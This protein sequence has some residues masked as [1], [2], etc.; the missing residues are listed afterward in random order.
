MPPPPAQPRSMQAA[1]LVV[2]TA[3]GRHPGWPNAIDQFGRINATAHMARRV[4]FEHGVSL[5]A[6]RGVWDKIPEA[7]R[8]DGL[9]HDV[10]WLPAPAEGV[11]P[12]AVARLWM[13]RDASGRIGPMMV[14]SSVESASIGWLAEQ[15]AQRLAAVE[16][17]CRDTNSAELVRLSIGEAQHQIEDTLAML[18]GQARP[19]E[20]EEDLLAALAHAHWDGQAPREEQ[21]AFVT[22]ALEGGAPHVRVPRV[23]GGT[24]GLRAWGAFARQVVQDQRPV[25]VMARDRATFI[26]IFVGG[27]DPQ[28]LT[29]LRASETHTPLTTRATQPPTADAIKAADARLK[30]MGRS[31][32]PPRE[33]AS[34]SGRRGVAILVAGGVLVGAVAMWLV[35]SRDRKPDPRATLPE[36][37]PLVLKGGESG[38]AVPAPDSPA[39]DG[40][41]A[42]Q[43]ADT[44]I[45]PEVIRAR[46]DSMDQRVRALAAEQ[47][48]QGRP[49][50][51]L[52]TQRVGSIRSRLD[53]GESPESLAP[54]SASLLREVDALLS[55]AAGRVLTYLKEEA[56]RPPLELPPAA[57]EAWAP[58]ILRVPP[59]EGFE[60]AQREVARARTEIVADVQR[61]MKDSVLDIPAGAP[62]DANALRAA[63]ASHQDRAVR[64]AA[65]GR[66]PEAPRWAE[67]AQGAVE[68]AVA[69]GGALDDARTL[70]EEVRGKPVRAWARQLRDAA[71]DPEIGAAVSV[72]LGRV[73]EIEAIE[74]LESPDALLTVIREAADA[75]GASV[76]EMRTAWQAL[77]RRPWPAE[78]ADF[79]IL[80]DVWAQTTRPA[81]TVMA[82]GDARD[83]ASEDIQA[84]AQGTWVA[85]VERVVR[86]EGDL[87]AA[88]DAM[89]PLEIGRAEIAKLPA[90]ASF[91]LARTRLADAL[92]NGDAPATAALE[93][94]ATAEAT[95]E[96]WQKLA[97]AHPE[98]NALIAAARAATQ[99]GD[100]TPLSGVGPGASGWTLAST[101]DET[102]TFRA[103]EGKATLTFAKVRATQDEVTYLSTT[104]VSVAQAAAAAADATWGPVLRATLPD[105]RLDAS[106]PRLGVR[107]WGWAK[108]ARGGWELRIPA[109]GWQRAIRP[110]ATTA[111]APD[112]TA[113][114]LSSDA[115]VQYLPPHAAA[116]LAAAL[117]CR[118]PT[119]EEWTLAAKGLDLSAGNLRDV[120]FARQAAWVRM[121]GVEAG[122]ASP[123][124]DIFIP[125]NSMRPQNVDD[126]QPAVTTDDK[127]LWFD[128]SAAKHGPF[129]NLVGNVA[130]YM[131]RDASG[132]I[133]GQAPTTEAVEAS[134][135]CVIGGS[136]LSP[137]YP[138]L[139][140]QAVDLSRASG[141]FSDV[142]LR[143]AFTAAIS[144][145]AK[146]PEQ[147]L[148]DAVSE[149][150]PIFPNE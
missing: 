17:M 139:E 108:S 122:V 69:I 95:E 150:P 141:G 88:M 7:E 104:E 68:A 33:Q 34:S 84:D 120:Q 18:V 45:T 131:V 129:Q 137:N 145:S 62:L 99:P 110:R 43:G 93:F 119:I 97:V 76:T 14:M 30:A 128:Q 48:A 94:L 126:A 82:D 15:A 52:L 54:E 1:H 44:S 105:Y 55:E 8:L 12:G 57:Q 23:L 63:A 133:Q 75:S 112:V 83:H 125:A 51:E 41:G 40:R 36:L 32:P 24:R 123:A 20:S 3:M 59:R 124:T 66:E 115:P 38:G 16:K 142:G 28:T 67:Q 113:Q 101:T 79:A 91:S 138:T 127:A 85:G 9:T 111:L 37:R 64:D 117:G 78:T 22:T 35:L 47:A 148:R 132:L 72:L 80:A 96:P 86:S 29:A 49:I 58:R 81:I 135:V 19:G 27:P 65:A 107:T 39:V 87:R 73:R 71:R 5:A 77:A 118:L 2:V 42:A 143:L 116:T 89:E 46:I 70:E 74:Q 149:S 103:P 121:K 140:P 26:D 106:D 102:L 6:A 25:L 13:S 4:V 31:A 147:E 50:D 90:W 21:C 109:D 134:E 98:V 53:V 92:T 60:N 136:A 146:T 61:A 56:A 10:L 100:H 130:E 114:Q 11:Q 144:A